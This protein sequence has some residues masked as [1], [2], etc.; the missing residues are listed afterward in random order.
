M[1]VGGMDI[2]G[3]AADYSPPRLSPGVSSQP[4][5]TIPP[6]S[7]TGIISN[8]SSTPSIFIHYSLPLSISLCVRCDCYHGHSRRRC[9]HSR[10]IIM[11]T[12][13]PLLHTRLREELLSPTKLRV[14]QHTNANNTISISTMYSKESA[15]SMVK[16]LARLAHYYINHINNLARS[17][18]LQHILCTNMPISLQ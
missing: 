16:N 3:D 8:T 13:S 5:T 1:A 2:T 17:I 12:A 9:H 7:C 15:A 11:H 14:T 6:P 18:K 4:S 10:T